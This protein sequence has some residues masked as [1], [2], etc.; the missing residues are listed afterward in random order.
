MA[1]TP[2]YSGLLNAAFPRISQ[3]EASTGRRIRPQVVQGLLQADL[4]KAKQFAMEENIRNQQLSM[5][6]QQ[7]DI[8]KQQVADQN[9]A[10]MVGG[11]GQLAQLPLAYSA[12]KNLGWWG[13]PK[14]G[15]VQSTNAVPYANATTTSPALLSQGTA[16]GAVGAAGTTAG[17]QVPLMAAQNTASTGAVSYGSVAGEMGA[18]LGTASTAGASVGL[19]A[20]LAPAG[21]GLLGGSLLGPTLNK[22][23]PGGGKTGRVVGG[24]AGGAAAGA[25]MGSIVPGIGTLVGAAIGGLVG[26]ISELF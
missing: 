8:Q 3:Y 12:G 5:Q 9:R 26:G 13:T 14:P 7:L 16:Q 10:A 17:A 19:G 24:V 21:A 1:V 11:A 22:I 15:V 18:G 2:G 4:D 6:Q 23:L 25:A 20:V